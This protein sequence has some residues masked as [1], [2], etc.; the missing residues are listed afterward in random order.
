MVLGLGDRI[1]AAATGRRLLGLGLLVDE[2]DRKIKSN[3]LKE[4]LYR[5]KGWLWGGMPDWTKPDAIVVEA[6]RDIGQAGVVRAFLAFDLFMDEI[7]ADLA[8]CVAFSKQEMPTIEDRDREPDRAV[9]FYRRTGGTPAAVQFLCPVYRYFRL[10]R[11]RKNDVQPQA[12]FRLEAQ[13]E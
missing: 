11:D 12:G 7:A 6:R 10:A 9:R 1:G 13:G 2:I 5:R 4:Q 8:R 3:D